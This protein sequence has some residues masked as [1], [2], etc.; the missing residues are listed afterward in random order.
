MTTSLADAGLDRPARVVVFSAEAEAALNSLGRPTRAI[1]SRT[2]RDALLE[3]MTKANVTAASEP[4]DGEQWFEL[5]VGK[6][7]VVFRSLPPGFG[8]TEGERLIGRIVRVDDL[9]ARTTS[10]PGLASFHS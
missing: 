1:L 4:L 10:D 8:E 9:T 3:P 5:P 6:F 2:V 7:R